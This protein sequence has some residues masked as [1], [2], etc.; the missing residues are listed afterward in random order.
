MTIELRYGPVGDLREYADVSSAFESQSIFDVREGSGGYTLVERTLD[1]PFRKDYD[2]LESPLQWPNLVDVSKWVLVSAWSQGRRVGGA[3][4]AMDTPGVD[5]LA[6][7][8][9]LVVIWDLRVAPEARGAGVGT[10]LFDAIESWGRDH[11]CVE[12][13]VETQNVNVAACEFYRRRGCALVRAT[14][15]A[16]PNLPQETQLIWRKRID[17]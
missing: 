6:G 15:G 2:A 14:A 9:D 12:L 17:A 3:I 16:Y 5:M 13:Q 11:A 1:A 4:G 10:A 8:H 7:R